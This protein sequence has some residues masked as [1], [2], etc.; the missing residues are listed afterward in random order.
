[1]TAPPLEPTEPLAPIPTDPEDPDHAPSPDD[2]VTPANPGG[3]PLK[4]DDRIRADRIR[5]RFYRLSDV[6]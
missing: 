6:Y 5:S 2:P 3:W 1:M 4:T